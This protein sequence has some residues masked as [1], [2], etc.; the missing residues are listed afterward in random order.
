MIPTRAPPAP[1]FRKAPRAD[2]RAR[3]YPWSSDVFKFGEGGLTYKTE[4][5]KVFEADGPFC[6]RKARSVCFWAKKTAAETGE[7]HVVFQ[8]GVHE[9]LKSFEV[10][11]RD[12]RDDTYFGAHFG[13]SQLKFEVSDLELAVPVK[14]NDEWHHYCAILSDSGVGELAL[15]VDGAKVKTFRDLPEFNT[16]PSAI[17][18]GRVLE[19]GD[20]GGGGGDQGFSRRLAS[21]D[22]C[23]HSHF[24]GYIDELRLYDSA[25]SEQDV[26]RD[27]NEGAAMP[28]CEA[29]ICKSVYVL[30]KVGDIV[31]HYSGT[32]ELAT[33]Q[34]TG[35][36]CAGERVDHPRQGQ[37]ELC[38]DMYNIAQY[39]A[40]TNASPTAAPTVSPS[41][42][43]GEPTT[44]PSVTPPAPSVTPTPAPSVTPT[45]A[46]SVS[47]PAPSVTPTPV[48]SV[49]TPAPSVTPT[50]VPSVTPTPAPSVSTPAPSV[51]PGEPTPA[52]SVPPTPAPSVPPTPAPSVKP[53]PAPSVTPTPAPS[54]STPAPSVKPG[55]PTPAPSVTPTPAPSV[56][57]T[58]APSVTPTP[59][60]SVSTPAPSVKPGEPTLA[61]V[62]PAPTFK[63]S[64]APTP[65]PTP[66]PTVLPGIRRRRPSRRGHRR[67]V[68]RA[69]G[70]AD[71]PRREPAVAATLAPSPPD[72]AARTGGAEGP[73][74][75][76]ARAA[77]RGRRRGP[78]VEGARFDA[79]GGVVVVAL[80]GPAAVA[81]DGARW[82]CDDAR[83]RRLRD[84]A[85]AWE[86]ATRLAA[87][88]GPGATVRAGDGVALRAGAVQGAG[89][90]SCSPSN[91]ARRGDR[92]PV[93]AVAPRAVLTPAAS[94]VVAC[95]GLTLDVSAST[96]HGGRAWASVAW[97]VDA[98]PRG[99]RRRGLG[100][101]GLL[102][103]GPRGRRRRDGHR[104]RRPR[105]LPRRRGAAAL[106]RRRAARPSVAVAGGDDV[107]V[108]AAD[109]L[110]ARSEAAAS[111]CGDAAGGAGA[112]TSAWRV[113]AYVDE[114]GA[115]LPFPV[116][117]SANARD[118]VLEPYALRPGRA[119]TSP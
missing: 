6:C 27:Y 104:D 62:T 48:P 92:R 11:F 88:L 20:C 32:C 83:A 19:P 3:R 100:D 90:A 17:S 55:E 37:E 63:P 105:E 14:F 106:R 113:V 95:E 101:A 10:Y 97:T 8:L 54:V 28:P 30:F 118:F 89:A 50:P 72:A 57:P 85:C 7:M 47:T 35:G 67:A 58:P 93:A 60:P 87:T 4:G 43:P 114:A 1:P 9:D 29:S 2:G 86:S 75:R 74:P 71:G 46:P 22:D 115:A 96:G 51:K 18:V 49:S 31:C 59:A 65:G 109:G 94:T 33:D 23:V 64:D 39:C 99:A 73:T 12:D 119:S 84:A 36:D 56:T 44:A 116:D 40:W 110:H 38:D 21:E 45:P 91:A 111:G 102:S 66:G 77:R 16:R 112:V 13:T 15:S 24:H 76:P 5:L 34:A 103:R 79:S 69:L 25:L 98:A 70:A 80:N 107:R 41:E 26:Q 52:P 78:G 108:L 68:R 81:V 61:P 53:T 82:P 42:K 117:V